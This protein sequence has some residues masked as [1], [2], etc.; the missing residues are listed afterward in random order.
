MV[1]IYYVFKDYKHRTYI[2]NKVRFANIILLISTIL[3]SAYMI[4]YFLGIIALENIFGCFLLINIAMLI[5]I[6]Y[7]HYIYES[8][9]EKKQEYKK[10]ALKLSVVFI[11]LLL[12]VVQGMY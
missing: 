3:M 7:Q 9:V 5:Y 4:L 2:N 11:I 1:I 6:L 12:L 8:V 10:N